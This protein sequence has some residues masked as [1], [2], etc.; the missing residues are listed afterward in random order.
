[1]PAASCAPLRSS[2][3]VETGRR[4]ALQRF[5]A[6][7]HGQR[8][9][10]ERAGLIDRPERRDALHQVLPAAIGGYGQAAA[11][12]FAERGQIGLDAEMSLRAAVAK[13]KAGDHLVENQQR[14][15][16]PRE[17]S[18]S[19]EE[20]RR[21]RNHAHIGGH[22][23]DDHRGDG[24]AVRAEDA[25]DGVQVVVGS[26][27]RQRGDRLR[28]ARRSGDAQRGQ[29]RA[30]LAQKTIGVAVVAALEFDDEVATGGRAR[31]ADGAHGGFR[32]RGNESHA[33]QRRQSRAR[34]MVASSTSS[35]LVMP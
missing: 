34:S 17:A 10:R 8:I 9:A 27:E 31:Q 30:G 15:V 1:M 14:A 16:A 3:F 28:H 7:A 26:V 13:P 24:I 25:L 11:D 12:D 20:S 23:L 2:D 19:F 22:G 21:G 35:S 5:D 32:A 18:Q 6:G 33:L 4:E 29:A